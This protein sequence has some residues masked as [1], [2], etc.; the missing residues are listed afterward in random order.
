MTPLNCKYYRDTGFRDGQSW[1]DG[2]LL[3]FVALSYGGIVGIVFCHQGGGLLHLKLSD[4]RLERAIPAEDGLVLGR[5][6]C[7]KQ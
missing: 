2:T 5:V 3:Q 6:G 7:P 4:I 1:E